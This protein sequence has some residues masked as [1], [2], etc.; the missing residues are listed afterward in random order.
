MTPQIDEIESV[1]DEPDIDSSA[2]ANYTLTDSE[3]T[4][5]KTSSVKRTRS[6][7]LTEAGNSC[8]DNESIEYCMS[9]MS[10]RRNQLRKRFKAWAEDVDNAA[11]KLRCITDNALVNQS[12][13]LEKILND[14][15]T[16][17]DAI[18]SEQN[19]IR[20]QLN[21]FV[22]MLS[23]AQV[24][25]F[26]EGKAGKLAPTPGAKPVPTAKPASADQRPVKARPVAKK[27]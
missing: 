9:N 16:R 14:G 27:K 19:K 24:Q 2:D 3:P 23:S 18:V 6:S 11:T 22:S 21:S 5:H 25:I 12:M 13:R 10:E 4:A 7:T 1:F 15:K 8:A 17:I 20:E 26:D